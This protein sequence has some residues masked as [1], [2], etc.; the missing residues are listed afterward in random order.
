MVLC[1]KARE[2]RSPPG[3]PIHRPAG[4]A[5]ICCD[6]PSG[7]RRLPAIR[8][9]TIR[10]WPNRRP[11]P[12]RHYTVTAGWS[13]PV[14]RQAHNLKVTGSNPVPA[15]KISSVYSDV[16]AAFGVPARGGFFV[17]DPCP[18]KYPTQRRMA[19][20]LHSNNRACSAGPANHCSGFRRS[21]RSV[22][23]GTK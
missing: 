1:L 22:R 18:K 7:A 8:S 16:P 10:Q 3:L 4:A 17:S 11:P 19:G 12:K 14:A 13:S 15:T 21:C 6:R 9:S 5:G 23:S 2:S 20:E